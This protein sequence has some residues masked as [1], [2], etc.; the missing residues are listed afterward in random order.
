M[1]TAGISRTGRRLAVVL[2]L[3][4]AAVWLLCADV[5]LAKPVY[6]PEVTVTRADSRINIDGDVADKA[7]LSASTV[8]EFTERYPGDN[9]EPDVDTRTLVTYDDKYLYVAFVC[10]DD[11]ASVRA[12]MCQR[13][14]FSGN[15]AVGLMIDT[16]GDASWAYQFYVNPYGIQK[17]YLWTS[18]VGE[19]SGFDLIWESAAQITDSGYQ[20]EIAVPFASLRFPNRDVQSWKI[21]FERI[22]P[23]ESYHQYS[24]AARDRNEPCWPCQWGT[25][26]GISSVQPG[27]GLELLPTYVAFQS[28]SLSD[29]GNPA[30]SFDNQ[31]V[32][33]EMSLGGKYALSSDMT[34][35]ATYNPDF[36]Q[37]ESDA[38][39]VDVNTTI[40]LFFPERR[41]FFQ[42]GADVFRTP[43]NSF[44]TRTVNDPEYAVKFVSRK[45]GF[46][47]GVMSAQDENTAYVIPLEER[48]ELVVTGRSWV[49]VVRGSKPFGDAS[50]V[51]FILTDRRLEGGGYGTIASVDGS[52]RLTPTYRFNGQF[53][54]SFTGEPNSPGASARLN[55]VL[56]DQGS[57]TAVFDGES[58]SGNAGYASL[59]R[60]ARDW[61]FNITYSQVDPAY[62]TETG[63]DPWVDYRDGDIGTWYNIYPE[64][65]P[66]QQIQQQ[67]SVNGRWQYDGTRKWL[68]QNANFRADL[69]WAQTYVQVNAFRGTETWTSRLD[70]SRFVDYGTLYGAELN[71]GGHLSHQ[72]GYNISLN[73]RR[74]VARFAE[75]VGNQNTVAVSLDF[76]PI[77]RL[78]IEPDFQYVRSTHLESDREL[79]RQY[80]VRTKLSLQLNRELSV[81]LIV[82]HDNSK[83]ALYQGE[84]AN[85]PAYY[86]WSDQTWEIDPLITYRLSSFSVLHAG[87]THSF[88]FFPETEQVGNTWKL[89]ARQ[90]FIKLQYLFQV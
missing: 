34:M 4:L 39:Q 76:K 22:R 35:E 90:F 20:V 59:Q 10:L 23:R 19:D 82:Q 38:A 49:N 88:D 71:F 53:V 58:F 11:P 55:G 54:S 2:V 3:S 9:T 70:A 17:D 89:N 8:S 50:Q 37:I 63:Y 33:G 62:R 87:S 40:A 31:D 57:R 14:Q 21:N 25:G 5:L 44:Y 73:R 42:E 85:G 61:N 79:Y 75:A 78:V 81:R 29:P 56:F 41:P 26:D 18:I 80:I 12:T 68:Y 52:L 74:E 47:L 65:G 16:Y 27:K 30:S 48:S 51:G 64:S 43:F 13:D 24:W 6:N 86:D 7:W 1:T 83:A 77:D 45:S 67:V 66:F 32:Q 15:D 46:T 28:G 72:M 69:R 36:S 60:R 84:T